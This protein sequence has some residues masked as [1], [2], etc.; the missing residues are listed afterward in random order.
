MSI[1][2]RLIAWN[3][4]QRGKPL[5]PTKIIAITFAVIIAVGTGLLM[6]PASSR[7]G[8]SCAFLPAL[9]TATSATCVTGLTPF[10]TWSQ[11]SGLGQTIILMLIE[12]GGL[13]FMSAATLFIFLFRRRIGLKERLV[14][15]QALSLNDLHGVVHLQKTV[16]FGSLGVEALG[17]AILTVYF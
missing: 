9:F 7:S 2:N 6:L 10:D 13:G 4:R 17:A 16:L 11:W 15:A 14:M 1:K 5:S 3:M 8:E 12:I